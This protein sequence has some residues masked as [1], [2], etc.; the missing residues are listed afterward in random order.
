[1]ILKMQYKYQ[2]RMCWLMEGQK[3]YSTKG[4]QHA[5]G[6]SCSL[7]FKSTV[8]FILHL[9]RIAGLGA[10]FLWSHHFHVYHLIHCYHWQHN[11]CAIS[12]RVYLS[13][14]PVYRCPNKE[15]YKEQ[16]LCIKFWT[17]PSLSVVVYQS[18]QTARF[19]SSALTKIARELYNSRPLF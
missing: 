12:C 8:F 11:S 10:I 5:M 15:D 2:K 1:M 18:G 14:L 16:C 9:W 13:V 3:Q 7:S 6:A 19:Q 4:I 17:T